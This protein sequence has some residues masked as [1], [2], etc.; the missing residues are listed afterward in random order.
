MSEVFGPLTGRWQCHHPLKV[1]QLLAMPTG[2]FGTL[3]RRRSR[4]VLLVLGGDLKESFSGSGRR[5]IKGK[6]YWTANE[7]ISGK[8]AG[9]KAVRSASAEKT[10]GDIERA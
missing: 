7:S 1:M 9:Q 2:G 5:I 4:Q 6:D 10:R 8:A 3:L